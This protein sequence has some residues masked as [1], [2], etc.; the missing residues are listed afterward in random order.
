MINWKVRLRNK[1]WLLAAVPVTAAAIYSVLALFD[2]VPAVSE[3]NLV[4]A[5]TMIVNLLAE[6][7][8]V[9]DPTTEG[10]A[11]SKRA[12]CYNYPY[13]DKGDQTDGNV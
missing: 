8:I 11:D 2:I 4:N 13:C 1:T 10:I 3:S 9:I 12:L 7:G 5:L 6:I